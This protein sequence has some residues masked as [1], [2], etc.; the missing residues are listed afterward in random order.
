MT[1]RHHRTAA[2]ERRLLPLLGGT[3][4]LAVA[5]LVL[6]AFRANSGLPFA[7]G[8][9]VTVEVP[10][11]QRL[12]AN[13]AVRIAGIRVGRVAAVTAL[14]RPGA[15]PLA[16]VRLR[17][18]PDVGPLPVDT[19]VRLRQASVLGASYVAVTPGRSGRTVPDGGRLA[20]ARV[21]GSVQLTDL[22]DV[23]DRQTASSITRTARQSAAGLAGR[24]FPLGATIGHLGP[25]L[26]S[27]S[28][29]SAA[30]AAPATRLEPLVGSYRTLIRQVRGARTE[31]TGLLEGGGT[32]F[33]TLAGEPR[34]LRRLFDVAPSTE[35]AVSA[36]FARLGPS[37]QSLNR[38]VSILRPV[39]PLLHPSLQQTALALR[40]GLMPLRLLPATA[41]RLRAT[42][43]TLRRLARRPSAGGSLRRG[44]D[45]AAALGTTLDVLTPAQVTCNAISLWGENFANGFGS[46]GFNDGP[47]AASVFLTHLGASNEMLQNAKPSPNVAINNNP[48]ETGAECESG[49]EPYD[50]RQAI[51]NPA[52]LQSTLTR[53]TRPPAGT[54]E[55]ARSIGLITPDEVTP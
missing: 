7:S 5:L 43:A 45:V 13:D 32:T 34:S 24:G 54:L 25:T 28:R 3:T 29:V 52:G 26:G 40:A 23:F 53:R 18:Q 41:G 10:D 14:T 49:N 38:T 12:V 35:L 9:E 22:L 47:S 31:L 51:G 15:A 50:G 36:N 20:A 48:H 6:V 16:R 33:G 17:L 2:R 30:L 27:L 42:L 1:S 55:R 21:T 8:Y 37:L 39:G 11:A 46:L 19:V 44:A 4:L